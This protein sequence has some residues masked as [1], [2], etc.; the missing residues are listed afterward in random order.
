VSLHGKKGLGKMPKKDDILTRLWYTLKN[1]HLK[2]SIIDYL[3]S[4]HSAIL[5][6]MMMQNL[7]PILP[8]VLHKVGSN[9]C[10]DFFSFF[11]QHVKNKHNFCNGEVIEETSHIG[12]TEKIKFEGDGP[13][14][15]ESRRQNL[16]WCEGNATCFANHSDYDSISNRVLKQAWLVSFKE[17]Q[18]RALDV[19]MKEVLLSH[20]KWE[21]PWNS[22]FTISLN[23]IDYCFS[24]VNEDVNVV[25]NDVFV[26]CVGDESCARDDKGAIMVTCTTTSATGV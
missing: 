17:V 13:L 6:I 5:H 8:I 25:V 20:D 21:N 26:N 4:C 15:L 11:G 10:E 18:N 24:K 7:F 16:F 1:L 9:C 23:I 14:F 22:S 12:Q 2:E 19:E 3:I